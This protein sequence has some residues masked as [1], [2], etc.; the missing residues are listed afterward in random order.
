[1]TNQAETT[2]SFSNR[3]DI[4]VCRVIDRT[5]CY[6][7]SC[8]TRCTNLNPNL[9]PNRIPAN[10]ENWTSQFDKVVLSTTPFSA[11]EQ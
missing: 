8:E 4:P 3:R 6:A 2:P 7:T 11:H 1:M 5:C 9:W 10:I